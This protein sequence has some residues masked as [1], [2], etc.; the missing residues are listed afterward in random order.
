[1]G[2]FSL[3]ALIREKLSQQHPVASDD[4]RSSLG[5]VNL[6]EQDNV[7]QLFSPSG[8][9]N[10]LLRQCVKRSEVLESALQIQAYKVDSDRAYS[11]FQHFHSHVALF[12]PIVEDN[13]AFQVLILDMLN[14]F[15]KLHSEDG[16]QLR[17]SIRKSSALI[18]LCLSILALG[19]QFSNLSSSE[20]ARQGQDFGELHVKHL[21]PRINIEYF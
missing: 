14:D 9:S 16:S 17:T 10:D 15:D 20:R 12:Y 4:V 6:H 21:W 2:R 1:M 13:D 7:P 5:L 3:A 18:A 19:A 8:D 11:F